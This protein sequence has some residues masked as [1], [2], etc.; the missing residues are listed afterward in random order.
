[1]A[2][3]IYR[4]IPLESSVA[5]NDRL[6]EFASGE[7]PLDITPLAIPATLKLT[8]VPADKL[9]ELQAAGVTNDTIQE[10]V[11]DIRD[12]DDNIRSK[13]NRVFLH[14]VNPETCDQ[15]SDER[16][17]Q[18]A[19]AQNLDMRQYTI[20]AIYANFRSIRGSE[21][22]SRA[23]FT[24]ENQVLPH[25]PS[26][27]KDRTQQILLGWRPRQQ[28]DLSVA[29]A[30]REQITAAIGEFTIGSLVLGDV[31]SETEVPA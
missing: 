28:K 10:K 11:I 21:Y 9:A 20:D 2:L 17:L 24:L 22:A 31:P 13:V 1:M 8:V 15:Y 26:L 14:E 18:S 5:I 16:I 6:A 23:L 7:N 19:T 30:I 27:H 29:A 25:T 3:E 4:T 12:N